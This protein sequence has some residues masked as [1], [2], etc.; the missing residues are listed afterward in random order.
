MDFLTEQLPRG[1]GFQSA[2][3]AREMQAR[4][5]RKLITESTRNAERN[6]TLRLGKLLADATRADN[7]GQSAKAEKIRIEFQKALELI[8][9][10]YQE[11]IA[12]GNMKEA[13]K[14]PTEQTLRNALMAELYPGMQLD[15]VGKLKR[16]AYEDVY[17]TI[18][19]QDDEDEGGEYEVESGDEAA[20]PE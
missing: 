9:N 14:P 4:Q 19:V 5:A 18:M 6:N 12:A 1:G 3:I 8:F 20:L 16:Q 13:V 15:R 2:R 17:Q 11:E 10:N 7:A